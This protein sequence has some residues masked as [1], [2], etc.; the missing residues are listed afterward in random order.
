M[1]E[2]KNAKI[3]STFLGYEDHGIL[4]C[5]IHLDYG[6]ISQS[7]GG[8]ELKYYGVDMISEILK[9]VKVE[10][11]EE[12]RGKHVRVYI[13]DSRMIRRIGNILEDIWYSPENL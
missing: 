11:W 3:S 9:V 5:F 8:Y 13:D 4:T 1:T 10:S 6:S 2:I 7:F 12:L